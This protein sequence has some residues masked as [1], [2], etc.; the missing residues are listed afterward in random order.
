MF[1]RDDRRAYGSAREDRLV[2]ELGRTLADVGAS[3]TD[4]PDLELARA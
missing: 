4:L 1:L 3:A 2:E